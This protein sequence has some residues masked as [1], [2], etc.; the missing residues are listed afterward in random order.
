MKYA[1]ETRYVTDDDKQ[2]TRWSKWYDN[3]S[4]AWEDKDKWEM[5]HE[6]IIES[7]SSLYRKGN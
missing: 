4:D 2:H 1:I 3:P 5:K 6:N 7:Q